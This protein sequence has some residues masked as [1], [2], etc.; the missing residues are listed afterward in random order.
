MTSAE[1]GEAFR[2]TY[3]VA[4]E[5]MAVIP[6]GVDVEH[7]SQDVPPIDEFNDGKL[8]ILYVSRL[9]KR[10]G[11][12]Y[13]L[14]AYK[15]IKKEIPD[16]RLIIVGASTRWSKK[17]EWKARRNGFP[18]V[19]FTGRV[20]HAELPRYYKT[21]DIVCCPATG[22]E[23]F[24]I[25]LLEAMAAGKPIVASN[26]KGYADVMTHDSEG[27]LV[28]PRDE[29]R[30]AQALVSLANDGALRQEMGA[31]GRAKVEQYRWESIAVRVLNYYS[32]V[33]SKHE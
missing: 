17:Y 16:S 26:I 1:E 18:G 12:N 15:R 11:V 4:E 23:S 32:E 13:L 9:E 10:K 21:A 31:R 14:K 7:F 25:I 33:L 19:T 20:P 29:K 28:P 22:K 8:N 6:N 2:R 30:L 24:G 3:R 27:L 5:R